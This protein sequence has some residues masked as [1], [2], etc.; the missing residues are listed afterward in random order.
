MKVI[1][2]KTNFGTDVILEEE[3]KFIRFSFGGNLDLYW[4]FYCESEIDNTNSNYF[5]ITKENYGIYKLFKRLF[6]WGDKKT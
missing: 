2:E 5:I 6:V 3:D 1:K 4:S